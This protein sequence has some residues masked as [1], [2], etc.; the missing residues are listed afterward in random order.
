MKALFCLFLFNYYLFSFPLEQLSPGGIAKLYFNERPDI[1]INNEKQNVFTQKREKDWMVLLPLSLYK[2]PDMLRV[3]S[4]TSKMIQV[5]LISLK[6]EQYKKQY[7]NVKNKEFVTASEKTLERIKRES[8]LKREKFARYTRL[9]IQDLKMIKPLD[10]KLR[11]DYGRR[12]FFNGVA[13][14]PHA[15]IDLSGK[16]GDRI[17]APLSGTVIVLGDLFYN[18][19]MMLIDHGQGLITAYSHLS[20]IYL[21]DESWVKQGEYIGEV[22]QS[23]RVTGPHLHWS[24][25]LNGEPVNPDLFLANEGSSEDASF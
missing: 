12:R 21:E 4:Q 18:G 3:V 5:H 11:H 17:K 8:A 13:K 20:K 7:L 2:G 1:Y 14:S 15:G 10:S 22:G 23:G 19:K 25:Y 16:Q 6:P 24:V 9:Y